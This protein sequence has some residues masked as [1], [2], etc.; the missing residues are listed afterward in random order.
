MP[1]FNEAQIMALVTPV[2]WPFLRVLGVFS[3]AP[4]FSSR[5]VPMRTRVALALLVALCAQ[6]GM[7]QAPTI[8]L[9]DP[10]ALG[11]VL[12]QVLVGVAIGLA[13]RIVFSAVELAGELIG[14][15][16]A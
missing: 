12:Q 13:A 16:R 3:S 2:F 10:Q 11:A 14:L 1:T 6:A 15:Q 9:N 4:I 8:G 7:P 5:S